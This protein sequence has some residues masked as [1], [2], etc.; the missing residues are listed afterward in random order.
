MAQAGEFY[1]RYTH[2]ND[3]SL[4]S[5]VLRKKREA[6]GDD[7]IRLFLAQSFLYLT[8]RQLLGL[9]N[10]KASFSPTS[11]NTNSLLQHGYNLTNRQPS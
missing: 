2:Q 6:L 7:F 9:L 10:F 4:R 5:P 8:I 3:E 11:S 1:G